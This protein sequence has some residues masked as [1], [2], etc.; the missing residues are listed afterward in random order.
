MPRKPRMPV[1]PALSAAR[2]PTPREIAANEQ[3]TADLRALVHQLEQRSLD[4]AV[5]L[6]QQAAQR[7][8]PLIEHFKE[9]GRR[10]GADL[11]QPPSRK[12]TLRLV[13][14]TSANPEERE[15]A[16][17]EAAVAKHGSIIAAMRAGAI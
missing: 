2:P 4:H 11:A 14:S 12:P 17:I 3:I 1:A 9:L 10:F 8:G 6:A 13:S 15:E 7:R 5:I 16:R